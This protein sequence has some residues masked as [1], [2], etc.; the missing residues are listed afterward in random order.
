MTFSEGLEGWLFGGSFT[1][2]ASES[3]WQDYTCAGEDGTA[4]I[5]SAVPEPVGFALLGQEV[6]AD[7]FRG[8]CLASSWPAAAGSSCASRS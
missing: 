5:R 6:L 4:V 8:S 2:H 7:D 3:H 1:E